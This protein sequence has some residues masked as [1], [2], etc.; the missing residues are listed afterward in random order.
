[1]YQSIIELFWTQFPPFFHAHGKER[2]E[3]IARKE[4]LE[5]QSTHTTT[6][7]PMTNSVWVIESGERMSN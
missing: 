2:L 5:K 3:L 7:L 1:M 6:H 4:T